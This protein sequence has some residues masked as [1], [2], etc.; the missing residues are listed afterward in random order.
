M[1]LPALSKAK[2]RAQAIK[3]MSNSRQ[4]M[5]AWM[6]YTV[7]YNDKLVNNFGI[8]ETEAEID[9]KTDRSWVNNVMGWDV[10]Y[11]MTNIEGVVQTPFNSYV[12][13]NLKV[14]Q[15]PADNFLSQKQRL[16][17]I[18]ARPRS[19]SMSCYMGAYNPTWTSTANQFYPDYLQFLAL[20]SIRA[21][22]NM[23][24]TLDEHPDSIND[25]F[26]DNNANPDP[27]VFKKWNDL[28]A[29]YHDGAGGF[30][31]AD[32]HAEVHKWKS[33]ICTILPVKYYGG[34]FQQHPFADD[35][36]NALVDATW[37]AIHSSV[38]K[39]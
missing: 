16:F 35:P 5:F 26:F 2:V 23:Y 14:Y 8:V 13:R 3:C 27:S 34:I 37:I 29:S 15:C 19:Y 12:A 20:K 28:P 25:G 33:R 21:P 31:F 38:R 7:D 39:N 32:G 36:A 9:N 17:G 4:L 24:V 30:A 1:L 11:Y 6:Q 10:T 22:A 18:T